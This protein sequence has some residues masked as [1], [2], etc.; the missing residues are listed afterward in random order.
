LRV[1]STTPTKAKRYKK[2]KENLKKNKFKIF[3]IPKI[4]NLTRTPL[5]NIDKLVGPSACA[6]EIQ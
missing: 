5:K 6:L 2:K 1:E 3:K 4:D